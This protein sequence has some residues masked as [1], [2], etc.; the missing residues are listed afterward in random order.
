MS[1]LPV[2]RIK[3]HFLPQEHKHRNSFF[4]RSHSGKI[5]LRYYAQGTWNDSSLLAFNFFSIQLATHVS[6]CNLLASTRSIVVFVGWFAYKTLCRCGRTE[7]SSGSTHCEKFDENMCVFWFPLKLFVF[8]QRVTVTPSVYS[9]R[10][11]RARVSWMATFVAWNLVAGSIVSLLYGDDVWQAKV[12]L[13]VSLRIALLHSVVDSRLI[14]GQLWRWL[15][16]F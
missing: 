10:C 15:L 1:G 6:S 5:S 11:G 16:L 14:R 7:K 8:G 3:R 9:S 13:S 2:R 12:E 4:I